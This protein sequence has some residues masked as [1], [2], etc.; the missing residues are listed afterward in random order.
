MMSV[1]AGDDME[2]VATLGYEGPFSVFSFG[3]KTV[4]FKAPYSLEKY[5]AVKHWDD[6]YL[7][8]MAKYRHHAE[9]EE[10]YIDLNPILNNLYI[11]AKEF[12][13]PIKEVRIGNG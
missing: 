11:N 8:V 9:P 1:K 3:N 12:L 10:E 13:G 2:Q 5:T 6:G 4:R 7:V